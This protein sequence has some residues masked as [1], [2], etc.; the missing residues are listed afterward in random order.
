MPDAFQRALEREMVEKLQEDNRKLQ[1]ELQDLKMQR[2]LENY[3][4]LE[5]SWS[6]VSSRPQP[7]PPEEENEPQRFTPNGT[8]VPKGPPPNFDERV[9]GW[10]L[11][12]Y[13]QSAVDRVWKQLGPT[14]VSVGEAARLH[15]GRVGHGASSRHVRSHHDC[16][17]GH[18]ARS[19]QEPDIVVVEMEAGLRDPDMML[20]KEKLVSRAHKPCQMCSQVF[21]PGLF[22]LKG[23]WNRSKVR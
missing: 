23:N 6:D 8:K 19:R 1:R 7:P 20:P 12:P 5:S 11:G 16:G 22:G 15:D 2:D 21:R 18:G 4:G 14:A 17:P 10:P 3:S 13:E 9:P